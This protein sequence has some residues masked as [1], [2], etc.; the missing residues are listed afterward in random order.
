MVTSLP[1]S[2]TIQNMFRAVI[3]AHYY[4]TL[5]YSYQ[6]LAP[7]A[8]NIQRVESYGDMIFHTIQS[9]TASSHTAFIHDI[10]FPL[11]IVGTLCRNNKERQSELETIFLQSISATGF[12]CNH[13]ALQMLRL[14]WE[15]SDQ[16]GHETWIQ[17]ARRNEATIGP[18]VI[19]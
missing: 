3:D 19:F 1:E 6:C 2:D 18:F 15:K 17:F 13:T 12:W 8:E 16:R 7:H 11:F 14:F 5:V 4:A 9:V 10:F